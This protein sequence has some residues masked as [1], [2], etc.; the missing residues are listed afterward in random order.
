MI[1]IH[2]LGLRLIKINYPFKWSQFRPFKVLNK[3][4]NF[5]IYL[6]PVAS[7]F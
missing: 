2:Y 5:E 1:M 4:E 6:Y 3:G 7:S